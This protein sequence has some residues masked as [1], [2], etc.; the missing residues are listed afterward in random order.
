MTSATYSVSGVK[1]NDAPWEK[2]QKP[3]RTSR[4]ASADRRPRAAYASDQPHQP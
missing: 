3:Q 4:L 1:T 2:A